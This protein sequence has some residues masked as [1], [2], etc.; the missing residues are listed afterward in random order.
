MNTLTNMLSQGSRT[1]SYLLGGIVIIAALVVLLQS[2]NLS[3]VAG[4]ALDV[5]GWG[6][7][8]LLSGLLFITVFSLVRMLAA[9]KTDDEQDF[10]LDVGLQSAN[11]VTTL[12]L[13]YT[14]LGISLGI[15]GLAAQQLSPETVQAVIRDLTGNFSLAFMTTVIGLP[16][17]AGLRAMMTITHGRLQ[18]QGAHN[19]SERIRS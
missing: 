2:Q 11:G 10:W 18:L 17:S 1:A 14:L 19:I 6:F 13:T 5:L 4:W 15:G 7:L 16:L 8:V 12:A 3:I 9:T